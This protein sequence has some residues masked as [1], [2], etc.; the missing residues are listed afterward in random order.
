MTIRKT[1]LAVISLTIFCCYWANAAEGLQLNPGDHISIVGD[2]LADRLQHDG[3][4]ET[5]L[6][7]QFPDRRLVIRNLGFAGDE[8]T[9]QMRCDNFGS[10]DDWLARTR[11]DVV[12][13][14]FGYNESFAGPAGVGKFKQDLANYIRNLGQHK[15]NSN[16]PPRL[17]L[18]S[19]IGHENLH[20]PNLPDGFTNNINLKLYTEA[21]AEVAKQNGILFVDLYTPSLEL[22][23]KSG[24]ALT[25]DG[26]HLSDAGNESLAPVI[27]KGL[28]RD[29]KIAQHPRGELEKLR[30]AVLDKN[31]YWYNRY[32]T[33]DGYNVYGG[34][35]QMKYVDDI[36]NWDVLQREMAALDVMS[37]NRDERIWAIAQGKD[38]KVDDS[39]TPPF[40][41]VKSNKPGPGPHGEH[42]FL[43]PEEA[44][45]H[46]KL[47]PGL[48]VNLFASEK[49]YPDLAKPVQMAWDPQGRLWVAV[50]PS[51]PHWKPK[52]E[53]NDKLLVLE[54]TDGDGKADKCTV[55]A[56]HL[57]CPTGF[58]F[59]NGGVL[60][61]QAPDLVFL[62]DTH[63]TG[64]ADFIERVLNG[65]GSADTHHTANSFVMDPGGALYFQE[66]V[67][68]TTQVETPYGPPVRNANAGVYRYEPR[69]HKFEV[70][71]SY[72]FANPHGHVF[73][74]WGE[75]FVMDGTGAEPYIGACFSGRTYFPQRHKRAPKLYEQRTRP[76]P[77][78]DVLS[79][80]QFPDDM[81]GNLLVANVIGFLG[82]LQYRIED[83]DSGFIGKE[84][85]PFVQSD[86]PNFRPVD[87]KVGPDGAVYFLEW[88]NP[89]IGH[90][91]HHLRDP[92]RDHIH[93]R[94]YRVVCSERPLQKPET[95]TGASIGKL[96][97]LLREPED[98]VRYRARIELGGRDSK[99][100]VAAVDDWKSKLDSKDPNYEHN[101]MEALWVH[102]YHNAVD[103]PLLK[104]MLRSPDFH[105]RAAATR[106]L[107]YWRDRVQDPLALLKVQTN[108]EHPRVRLEA[109]RACSFFTTPQAA[110]VALEVLN[111]PMD[112]YLKYTL[113]ETM[114]TLD[115]F[116]KQAKE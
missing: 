61:A 48:K 109:V 113:D 82:I 31:F 6:Q 41:A 99:A 43:D 13:G 47:A 86:D 44:I 105:A 67:F 83:K 65:I 87:I 5:L 22:Y 23:A 91:Q 93:G 30:A 24:K 116:T 35:S 29:T 12:F 42:S 51:Y 10:A 28:F 49:E 58:E 53:M 55:F 85:T 68:H 74:R 104:R 70:Y 52:D 8:L 95:I 77:G 71:V 2:G 33:V 81:Q 56:D 60:V 64:K 66:G 7:A 9:T 59:Y 1:F 78:M 90:L 17:V 72:D 106:V 40:L 36:S 63:G 14:F 110:E 96:L 20:D 80:R 100:V 19:P 112:P 34:R 75:D 98:R 89:I 45:G 92:S 114:N 101:L 108:D 62:K 57:H 97:D 115:R 84:V 16:T 25:I 50:W 38:L 27:L 103:E 18:F 94:I 76:C 32:R 69:T 3:W 46:M 39:N 107:C 111:H 88:Q 73:D 79:S 26:V 4:L 54:D 15:Y 11:A 37:A 21:I 102:Q